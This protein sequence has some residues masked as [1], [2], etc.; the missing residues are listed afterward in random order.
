MGGA[1]YD[2]YTIFFNV[3]H[4]PI[5]FGGGLEHAASQFDI[6]PADGFADADGTLGS[7]M[8]PLTSHE[9]FHLWNVKRARP[10]EMWPYDY[11]RAQYTPLLWWS[12]GVTDYYGDVT[13]ARSRLWTLDQFVASMGADV[14]GL[15]TATLF[16]PV[17]ESADTACQKTAGWDTGPTVTF[18]ASKTETASSRSAPSRSRAGASRPRAR[19]RSGTDSSTPA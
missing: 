12:E 1:P 9:F 14:S 11:A 3:Y 6:M 7:F 8:R 4:E 5:Q 10:A 18:W 13:L 15:R 16:F 2:T 19:E 17:R